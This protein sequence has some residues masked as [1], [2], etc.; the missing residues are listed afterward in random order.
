MVIIFLGHIQLRWDC[1]VVHKAVAVSAEGKGSA[2]ADGADGVQ[3]VRVLGALSLQRGGCHR[4]LAGIG[5]FADGG[6]DLLNPRFVHMVFFQKTPGVCLAGVGLGGQLPV[7]HI[8]Q[9]R[10]QLDNLQ[11]RLFRCGN[12]GGRLED[13]KGVE[14]VVSAEFIFEKRLHIV[15]CVFNQFHPFTAFSFHNCFIMYMPWPACRNAR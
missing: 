11:I 9:Q 8:V 12:A 2:D 13:T 15:Q 14:V 4:I 3:P 10:C 1:R 7:I 6:D 5:D